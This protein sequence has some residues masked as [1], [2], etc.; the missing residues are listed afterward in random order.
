MYF[1]L[2]NKE[3]I[4][5]KYKF[6]IK[7]IEEKLG[8]PVYWNPARDVF[9]FYV[10]GE[11]VTKTAKELEEF[12]KSIKNKLSGEIEDISEDFKLY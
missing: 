3:R 9:Y 8:I 2:S 11:K 6:A 4:L 7:S 10:K 1:S 12:N 5:E